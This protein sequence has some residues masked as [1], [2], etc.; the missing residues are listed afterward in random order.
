MILLSQNVQAV[1][2]D[3]ER[4]NLVGDH[5][6]GESRR[7]EQ[8]ERSPRDQPPLAD[9]AD[10]VTG[11]TDALEPS[12]DSAGRTNLADQVD[13]PHINPEFERC[14]G[15]DAGQLAELEGFLGRPPLLLAQA[16]M[17][18]PGND[19]RR[20]VGGW[21]VGLGQL[22]QSIRELLD[23]PSVVGENDRR[24]VLANQPE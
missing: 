20:F 21:I 18:R 12:G 13:R 17:M 5:R 2:R 19:L 8:V 15:D 9:P 16:P 23:D 7:F 10:D 22:V 14:R 11:A 1:G 24:A 6:S 4:L 3:P